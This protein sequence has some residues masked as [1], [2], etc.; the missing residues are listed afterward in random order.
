MSKQPNIRITNRD[1]QRI[2]A[3][4]QRVSSKKSYWR[5]KGLEVQ[6]IDTRGVDSFSSRKELNN[7]IEKMEGFTKRSANRFLVKNEEGAIFQKRDLD[8]IENEI[9]KVNREKRKEF[10]RIKNQTFKDRDKPTELTVE[11]Q[12]YK[13]G[14]ARFKK[15][16]QLT[17]NPNRYRSKKE[18]QTHLRSLKETYKGDFIA[19]GNK[20]YK[21]NYLTALESVFG[22]M[23]K[24]YE[25][26]KQKIIETDPQEL[27]DMKYTNTI[28]D[29]DFIYD[30]L[31]RE[32]KLHEIRNI[33]GLEGD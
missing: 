17:F 19:R 14:D 18:L 2:R 6:G 1:R 11:G 32:A 20:A 21:F 8:R 16:D 7:Y 31:E 10:N 15:L 4:N 24:D 33:F 29:I 30:K 13:M 5:S 12:K 23:G 9:R 25:T 26:L 3:L 27:M 22:F 28:G